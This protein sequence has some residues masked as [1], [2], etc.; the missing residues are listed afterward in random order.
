MSA[1]TIEAPVEAPVVDVPEADAD[2]VADRIIMASVAS[3]K[4]ARVTGR[5]TGEATFTAPRAWTLGGR[6]D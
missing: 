4:T 6:V 1:L 5:R 3:A 2:E